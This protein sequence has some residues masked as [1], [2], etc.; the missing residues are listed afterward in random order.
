M[1]RLRIKRVRIR[2]LNNLAKIHHGNAIRDV[3]YHGQ[4][5]GDKQVGH[6]HLALKIKK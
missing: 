6:S 4:I 2:I 5:V 1:G 3:L